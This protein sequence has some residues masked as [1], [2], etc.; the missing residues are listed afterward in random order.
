MS[1]AAPEDATE[2]LVGVLRRWAALVSAGLTEEAAWR[3]TARMLPDDDGH[4][5][6][7]ARLRA[8]RLAWDAAGD[9]ST[10]RDAPDVRGLRRDEHPPGDTHD[11]SP[12]RSRRR[13][14]PPWRTPPPD[15]GWALVDAALAAGARAGAAPAVV[16]RRLAES[17]EADVDAARARRS[18]AAGPAATARLLQWL[19]LGGVGLAWLLG[20]SPWET[21]STPFGA[22]VA[23]VGLLFWLAG[24]SWTRLL[25]RSAARE[26][27]SLTAPVVLDVLAA[28]LGAG[29]SLPAALDDLARTL[30]GAR[31]LRVTS[32]LLLWGRGWD[33]AWAGI[34]EGTVWAEAAARLRPLHR[35][36][37]AG[38]RTLAESAAAA[39]Q[40]GRRADERAAEEL[41]VRLVMPLGLCL[42]PAFVC[43][44]VIPVVMALLGAGA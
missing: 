40:Q 11:A 6:H 42:L 21:V 23:A 44:G 25:L 1:T 19:P 2:E 38:A 27:A 10:G 33:E 43:W 22:A 5:R 41:A 35:S 20:S 7:A 18:A 37:M 32:A 24:R 31:G 34:G 12:D 16:V 14:C 30:P 36:G 29:R 15:P 3:E 17:L 8:E 13:W 39:R 4:A 9:L 26:P 28:L